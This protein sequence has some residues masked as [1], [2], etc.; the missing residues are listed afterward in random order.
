MAK[1]YFRSDETAP[2][3]SAPGGAVGQVETRAVLDEAPAP[4]HLYSH[5]LAPGAHLKLEKVPHDCLLYVWDGAVTVGGTKLPKGSS[6]TAE[7]GASLEVSADQPAILFEF[8][9]KA[10]RSAKRSG[11]HV[12]LL[13]SDRVPQTHVVP[14]VEGFEAETSVG[15][16]LHANSRCPTCDVWLH[17][18]QFS[19]GEVTAI[20]SHSADEVIVV[21]AGS[22]KLGNKLYGPG[23]VLAVAANA[24][25]GFTAGPDGLSFL[26]YRAG[27]SFYTSADGKAVLDEATLM[28]QMI[29]QPEYLAAE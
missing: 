21:K 7:S 14:D 19:P 22:A 3:V 16:W 20:H 13:P 8:K 25:Y 15:S 24:K 11:H 23:S 26:N 9:S 18:N 4:I 5:R 29:G 6:V 17:E 27:P 28:T 1:V 12:H 2:V 10:Y